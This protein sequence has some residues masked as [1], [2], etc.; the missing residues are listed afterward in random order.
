LS[1][2]ASKNELRLVQFDQAGK[3]LPI[4]EIVTRG[5]RLSAFEDFQARTLS[6]LTGLW[7]KLLYMAELRRD[8]EK[9]CHWGHS[10]VHGESQ[11]QAALAR[12]HSE[13]YITLLRTPIRELVQE[14]E[15]TN[16]LPDARTL[17]QKIADAQPRI[18]PASLEGG[19]PRHFNSV[20][21]AVSLVRGRQQASSHSA[22]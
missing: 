3:S 13:L 12:A 7:A 15:T 11:S 22:A 4:S 2:F 6:A 14:I 10:R 19:S 20:V 18:F 17:E 5:A 1:G 16:S 9:Y 21:L 8:G